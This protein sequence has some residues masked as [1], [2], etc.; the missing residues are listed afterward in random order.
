VRAGAGAALADVWVAR[1]SWFVAT[2]RLPE[3]AALLDRAIEAQEAVQVP[4]ALASSRLARAQLLAEE[5]D[6]KGA[7]S[8]AERS[9][10][11]FKEAGLREGEQGAWLV[12]AE[13]QG[14][15]G[16]QAEA[17]ESALRAVDLARQL[18]NPRLAAGARAE[19]AVILAR[20]GAVDEAL[21]EYE[22]ATVNTDASNSLLAPR[23]RVRLEVELAALLARSRRGEEGLAFAQRAL[24]SASGPGAP[25]D[26]LPLG[27][28][29]VV[30]VLL[31]S[32][33]PDDALAFLDERGMT[34]GRLR[35]A[36]LD[37]RGTELFNQGVD[38]YDAG[39]LGLAARRFRELLTE[40]DAP[41]ERIAS[42][43][44]ALQ[45]V[46]AAH[47]AESVEA[48]KTTRA[49]TLWS[50][51]TEIALE[52]EDMNGAGT[53]LLLRAQLAV[54]GGEP[55]RAIKLASQCGEAMAALEDRM[56][57]AQCWEL[58]GHASFET[59]PDTSRGAFEN[60]LA[61]WASVPESVAHRAQLAY[62]LA[63]LDQGAAPAVLRSRLEAARALAEEAKDQA[64]GDELTTWIEQLET[65][66]AP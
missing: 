29:A 13:L 45:D 25:A 56:P 22:K 59:D 52:R 17:R 10:E 51:A 34:E 16:A 8:L 19:L 46:L 38:A 37:R 42:A 66:D 49:E 14:R 23:T 63:V 36:V 50:E 28:E 6:V 40:P 1:S 31:E 39:D 62:N 3:A 65:P 47:G 32:G 4:V 11:V 35:A 57:A 33:R 5:G 64:L 18:G 53:L 30:A 20:L 24:D 9:L 27:E 43:R 7:L 60:A 12:L 41:P 26:L 44:R 54:D 61:A 58:A 2:G 55:G 48:G 15:G 21:A